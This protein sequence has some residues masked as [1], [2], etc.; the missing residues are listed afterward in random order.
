MVQQWVDVSSLLGCLFSLLCSPGGVY[1]Y[2]MSNESDAFWGDIYPD[3]GPQWTT[4]S[5]I[6]ITMAKIKI[7]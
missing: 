6:K 7:I 3:N 1:P 2:Y 4:T 5:K